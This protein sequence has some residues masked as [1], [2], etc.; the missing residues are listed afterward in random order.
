MLVTGAFVVLFTLAVGL[1]YLH[2]H[3]L[4][5]H[6][7]H[8]QQKVQYQVVAVLGLLAMLTHQNWFWIAAL[9]LALVDLPDFGGVLSRIAD[10]VGR[11]AQRKSQRRLASVAPGE[12]DTGLK[13][14]L[15][16]R[17]VPLNQNACPS[18]GP[19]DSDAHR[20]SDHNAN[21]DRGKW[22]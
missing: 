19:P 4:P 13:K 10:S 17:A 5:D 3:H 7:A 11:I 14:V 8:K 12:P 18:A 22:R 20:G 6:I 21:D 1:V 9:L 16:D 2:L 15:P